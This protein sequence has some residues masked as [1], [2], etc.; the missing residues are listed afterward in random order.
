MKRNP[1]LFFDPEDC[2]AAVKSRTDEKDPFYPLWMRKPWRRD[3]DG[4]KADLD[5]INAQ[6]AVWAG[7]APKGAIIVANVAT[8]EVF[9][10]ATKCK[11][12]FTCF[13]SPDETLRVMTERAKRKQQDPSW[14]K[15]HPEGGELGLPSAAVVKGWYD[16]WQDHNI[17]RFGPGSPYVD[18]S[19]GLVSVQVGTGRYLSDY[20]DLIIS[21]CK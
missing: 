18:A 2:A 3:Y 10:K 20:E 5:A 11:L 6:Y 21:L 1:T 15:V 14:R 19:R 16:N 7:T 13:R 17:K 12:V 9:L 4:Y 8:S